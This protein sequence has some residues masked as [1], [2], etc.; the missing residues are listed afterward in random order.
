MVKKLKASRT[1]EDGK[2]RR[3]DKRVNKKCD[4]EEEASCMWSGVLDGIADHPRGHVPN[5]P[6][7]YHHEQSDAKGELLSGVSVYQPGQK[8]GEAKT[9]LFGHEH[10][11]CI[12]EW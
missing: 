4:E 5:E 7:L 6:H 9:S 3:C 12:V 10:F 8:A 1:N 11:T 2:K